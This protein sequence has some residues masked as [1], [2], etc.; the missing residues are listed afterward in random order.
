[1]SPFPNSFIWTNASSSAFNKSSQSSL[2]WGYL[3]LAVVILKLSIACITFENT[4]SHSNTEVGHRWAW[5]TWMDY[6]QV[7]LTLGDEEH[8]ESPLVPDVRQMEA[9]TQTGP[10]ESTQ[11]S[12]ISGLRYINTYH[13]ATVASSAS[14]LSRVFLESKYRERL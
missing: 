1:M 14:V 5:Y 7:F 9:C 11:S 10:C 6:P 8:F 3:W 13:L 12:N 4:G 2:M